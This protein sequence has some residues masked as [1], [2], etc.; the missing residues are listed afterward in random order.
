MPKREKYK[1]VET[2]LSSLPP[3]QALILRE[4]RRI[5]KEKYPTAKE[6]ISY[7]IPA[8][9][10]K[11]VFFY[12]AAFKDHISIF[13]PVKGDESLQKSLVAYRNARGNLRFP[14][15]EPMPYELI[16]RVAEALA[17]EYIKK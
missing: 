17:D 8:F 14:L 15:N 4:I 16:G 12:Y 13:P 1:V 2:Y 10:Q 6:V 11:K 5:V 7:N 9:K 3:Q